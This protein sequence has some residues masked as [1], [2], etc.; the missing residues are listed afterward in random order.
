MLC[1]SSEYYQKFCVFERK[2]GKQI[3]LAIIHVSPPY[4]Q[5]RWKFKCYN[6]ENLDINTL[7]HELFLNA[8]WKW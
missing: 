5:L 8:E 6:L 3:Q 2:S 7:A 1:I 4:V